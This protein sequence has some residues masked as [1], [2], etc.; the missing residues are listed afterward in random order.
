M[1]SFV[2]GNHSWEE[3]EGKERESISLIDGTN[4]MPSDGCDE[5]RMVEGAHWCGHFPKGFVGA[6]HTDTTQQKSKPREITVIRAQ[7]V[8]ELES[9]YVSIASVP[10]VSNKYRLRTHRR[11]Y[12]LR[13]S[14][15]FDHSGWRCE[16]GTLR[17]F[18]HSVPCGHVNWTGTPRQLSPG[19]GTP[20]R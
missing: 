20:R 2:G 4:S 13:S 7:C 9:Q 6:Q 15:G 11:C 18:E 17:L 16:H 14:T 8:G 1:V 12:G 19:T 3:P 5:R 10:F